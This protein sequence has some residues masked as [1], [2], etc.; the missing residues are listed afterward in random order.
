MINLRP[1][2]PVLVLLAGIFVAAIILLST[3]IFSRPT[4][5]DV[6]RQTQPTDEQPTQQAVT[7]GALSGQSLQTCCE[8]WFIENEMMRTTCVGEWILAEGEC[9]WLCRVE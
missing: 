2:H 1:P 4:D 5:P 7:C 8:N 3:A 9:S 6:L